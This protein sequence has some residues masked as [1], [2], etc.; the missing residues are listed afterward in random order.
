MLIYIKFLNDKIN[1]N[2]WSKTFVSTLGENKNNFGYE[3]Y[4]SKYTWI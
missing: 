3:K 2:L 1:V 4:L